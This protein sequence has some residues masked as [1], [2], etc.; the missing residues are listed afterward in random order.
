MCKPIF[1]SGKVVIL[2]SGFCVLQ[3]IIE[4]K[5]VG[6][7]AAALIKKRRYWPKHV[8]GDG[9]NAH[10]AH[11]EIGYSDALP[12][13]L[14]G[15]RFNLFCMKEPDYVMM[16]MSTYGTTS[17][18]DGQKDTRRHYKNA[19]GQ[20]VTTT[21]KYPEVI[22]NHYSYRGCVDDHNNKRQD[23]GKKQGLS[24]EG[25]WTTY[26]WPVRVFAFILGITEVNT[27]LAWVYFTGANIEF[28]AFRRRLAHSLIYNKFVQSDRV[29][30]EERRGRKRRAVNHGMMRAPPYARRWTGGGWDLSAKNKYQQYVCKT[31]G[32]KTPV[33]TYCLCSPGTW[34]C[35]VCML[36]HVLDGV[37]SVASEH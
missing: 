14:D 26:R 6:V 7:F 37:A 34:I 3:G 1:H 27:Y 31:P 29:E 9:I 2:D 15:V 32:C 11:K 10:F 33:R 21:F 16:L 12:G 8:D 24:L 17:P 36:D 20:I 4:L 13:V 23:G 28:M 25:T 22:G 35:A 5:K 18:K 19:Q 30:N